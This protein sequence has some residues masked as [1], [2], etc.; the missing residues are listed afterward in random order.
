MNGGIT[1]VRGD[2]IPAVDGM[3]ALE[4]LRHLVKSFVPP[5]PLPARWSAAHGILEPVFIVVQILQGDGLRANV[6]PAERVVFV[7]ADIETLAL[8]VPANIETPVVG[9]SIRRID[10]IIRK[11]TGRILNNDCD[12]TDRF[13]EIAVAIMM[14]AI[15][16][17]SHDTV[18]ANSPSLSASIWKVS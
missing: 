10:E 9:L 6:P 5:D 4:V 7:T 16:G 12:A 3:N 14:G 1:K 13:A 8:S 11:F 18:L 15:V 17:G 2:G